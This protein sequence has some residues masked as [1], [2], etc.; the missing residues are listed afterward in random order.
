MSYS[1]ESSKVELT[2][3]YLNSMTK[4]HLVCNYLTYES[5]ESLKYYLGMDD[6]NYQKF[7]ENYNLNSKIENNV[8]IV[9]GSQKS[10]FVPNNGTITYYDSL[11]DSNPEIINNVI[12]GIVDTDLSISLTQVTLVVKSVE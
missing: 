11:K 7:K 8:S 2:I 6:N 10:I 1:V 5:K 12:M 9:K 3:I 4:N